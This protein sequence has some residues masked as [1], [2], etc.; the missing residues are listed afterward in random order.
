[1][2]PALFMPTSPRLLSFLTLVE[3][4][5]IDEG[6]AGLQQPAVRSVNFHK[7]LARMAFADGSGAILLQTFVL[8]DGESCVKASV[9]WAGADAVVTE[10]VFPKGNV[11][12]WQSAASRVARAWMAGPPMDLSKLNAS[13]LSMAH[14][15]RELAATG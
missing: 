8:A 3:N 15:G 14:A 6:C 5:L 9:T 1:M 2:C 10:S 4:A 12:D 11:F 13:P 7:N